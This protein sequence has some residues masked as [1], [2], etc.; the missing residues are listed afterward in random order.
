MLWLQNA[1]QLINYGI[2]IIIFCNLS[3]KICWLFIVNSLK[4]SDYSNSIYKRKTLLAI[5]VINFC[6]QW[7]QQNL[8]APTS[9]SIITPWRT[10]PKY[11]WQYLLSM[12]FKRN[13]VSPI[14]FSYATLATY[15]KI[16]L[17]NY[18]Q[19]LQKKLI[20]SNSI[21]TLNTKSF[22]TSMIE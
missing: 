10:I 19:R 16:L 9:F 5:E 13:L 20:Y 7:L 21:F 18:C 12:A 15:L 17:A 4:N 8:I 3:Q 2:Y 11:C 14:P 6:C 22:L 1:Q